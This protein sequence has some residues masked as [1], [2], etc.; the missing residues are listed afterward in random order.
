MLYYPVE[1]FLSNFTDVLIT[2]NHEDY[3]IA[4]KKFHAKKTYFLDGVGVDLKKYS[5]VSKEKKAELREQYGFKENKFILHI[6]ASQSG[7]VMLAYSFSK[8][9]IVTNVG[10]LPE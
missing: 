3:E 7:V 1:K 6:E 2:I 4:K 5:S 8:P 10:G 9:V